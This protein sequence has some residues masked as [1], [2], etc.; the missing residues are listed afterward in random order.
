MRPARHGDAGF[1]LVEML[2]ALALLSM[3]GLALGR[4][5]TLQLGM[6]AAL[7]TAA[8]ADVVADN[9][10]VDLL[11]ADAP[12]AAG[13]A[14]RRVVNGGS[15]WLVTTRATPIADPAMMRIDIGVATISG[16]VLARRT[17]LKPPA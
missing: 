11:L 14:T 4:F 10:A 16:R 9:R 1:T 5:Q 3:V 17:L 2:V 8:V 12:P 15:D 13:A 7:A 6:G